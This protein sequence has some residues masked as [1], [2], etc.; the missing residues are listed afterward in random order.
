MIECDL[1]RDRDW[2]GQWYCGIHT[3]W[4]RSD[5][6]PDLCPAGDLAKE[7]RQ[8]HEPV[9]Q[10]LEIARHRTQELARDLAAAQIRIRGL[11][12]VLDERRAECATMTTDRD[13]WRDRRQP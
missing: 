10:E 6:D 4:F 9:E 1:Q 12:Q 5:G 11:E 8:E 3:V 7:I 13:W 2:A